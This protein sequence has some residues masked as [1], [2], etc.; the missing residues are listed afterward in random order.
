MTKGDLWIA[1]AEGSHRGLLVTQ[2]P[3]FFRGQNVDITGVPAGTYVLTHRTKASMRLRELRYD[4]DAASVRIRLTWR[5]GYPTVRVPRSCP[6][7]ANC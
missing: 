4:D 2:Y 7:T 6:A 5:K 3:A 1:D